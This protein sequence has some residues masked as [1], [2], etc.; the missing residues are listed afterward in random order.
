MHFSDVFPGANNLL[1]NADLN[2]AL[3]VRELAPTREIEV[4]LSSPT[5]AFAATH[6]EHDPLLTARDTIIIF[7]YTTDRIETLQELVD[8]LQVQASID[9]R[10]QLVFVNG[11]VR[12]PGQYP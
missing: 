1:P 9:Q 10:R 12:F 6:S 11:S 8:L 5:A 3:I 4:H 7:D 2:V